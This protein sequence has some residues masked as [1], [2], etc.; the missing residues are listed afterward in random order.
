MNIK[1]KG[2]RDNDNY[3]ELNEKIGKPAHD[4]EISALAFSRDQEGKML[5][6]TGDRDGKVKIWNSKNEQLIAKAEK[7]MISGILGIAFAPDGKYLATASRDGTVRVFEIPNGPIKE[8]KE[9]SR[10]ASDVFAVAFNPEDNGKQLL[11]TGKDHVL[12]K[13]LWQEK[14][15]VAKANQ[16]L[17]LL[18]KERRQLT[19][20]DEKIYG[21][22]D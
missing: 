9:V 2:E 18:P 11:I 14:D 6:A 3:N 1:E 10:I 17:Q 19:P 15:L 5:L 22:S 20:A 16:L 12:R 13:R 21:L 7:E 8:L 4:K